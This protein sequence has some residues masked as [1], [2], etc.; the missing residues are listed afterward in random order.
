MKN[1]KTLSSIFI[2]GMAISVHAYADAGGCPA[3][4]D[5]VIDENSGWISCVPNDQDNGNGEDSAYRPSLSDLLMA[6]VGHSDTPQLWIT[7][8][9]SSIQ[10]SERTAMD[11]CMA[12]IN[13]PNNCRLLARAHNNQYIGTVRNGR[14]FLNVSSGNSIADATTAAMHTCKK[15]SY[16]C[17][18]GAMLYNTLAQTDCF[19]Q[20]PI[21]EYL[22]VTVAWPAPGSR[23]KP[24]E[25]KKVW[26]TSGRAVLENAEAHLAAAE[27]IPGY[28]AS[29]ADTLA[30]EYLVVYMPTTAT[31]I[32]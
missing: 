10:D 25:N 16:S 8:G 20:V 18:E 3:R 31:I 21:K 4:Y 30:V 28:R 13:L 22:A 27:K 7:F 32:G 11:A 1:I 14:G 29:L 24:L 9:Y 2:L 6:V 5:A 17:Q 26:L 12:A 19:P 23:T 15:I